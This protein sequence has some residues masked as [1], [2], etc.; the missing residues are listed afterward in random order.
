MGELQS[1]KQQQ[2]QQQGDG[3]IKND[4]INNPVITTA[5]AEEDHSQQEQRNN[6]NNKR[7]RQV[8]LFL[9]VQCV[10]IFLNCILLTVLLHFIALSQS[11]DKDDVVTDADAQLQQHLRKVWH[12]IYCTRSARSLLGNTFIHLF[13]AAVT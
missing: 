4:S 6:N 10:G 3:L 1:R 9:T 11:S 2:K 7:G 12:I 13:I 8:Q 5:A